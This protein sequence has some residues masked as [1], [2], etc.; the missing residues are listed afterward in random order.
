MILLK[1][2]FSISSE[3]EMSWGSNDYFGNEYDIDFVTDVGSWDLV[4]TNTEGKNYKMTGPLC[5]DLQTASGGL[6]I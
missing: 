6:S 1:L 5:H 4:L 3:A 2:N